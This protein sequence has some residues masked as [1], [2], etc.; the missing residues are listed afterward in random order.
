MLSL[1]FI[2]TKIK[3]IKILKELVIIGGLVLI[4]LLGFFA[5]NPSQKR[6][7]KKARRLHKKGEIYYLSGDKELA[8]EYYQESEAARKK[9]RGME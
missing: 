5:L 8:E 2:K 6:V 4:F 7:F 1:F 9:A 3:V